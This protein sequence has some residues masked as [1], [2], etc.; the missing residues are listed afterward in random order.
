MRVSIDD[1]QQE[2]M[3]CEMLARLHACSAAISSCSGAS[4]SAAEGAS[5][6]DLGYTRARHRQLTH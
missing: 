2:A 6:M 5:P 1:S 3:I 4:F